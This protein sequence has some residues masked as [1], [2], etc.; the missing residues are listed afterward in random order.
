MKLTKKAYIFGL[1]CKKAAWNLCRDY[2]HQKKENLALA[3]DLFPERKVLLRENIISQDIETILDMRIRPDGQNKGSDICLLKEAASLKEKYLEELAFQKFH[4][5]QNSIQVN[6]TL[7]ILINKAYI[8]KE[9]IDPKKL[10]VI[11]DVTDDVSGIALFMKEKYE[12]ILKEVK[13]ES[14]PERYMGPHCRS[15][16]ILKRCWSDVPKGSVLELFNGG[17]RAF[18]LYQKS[19]QM[20]IDLPEDV[21]L[22]YA[23]TIQKQALQTGRPFINKA[24]IKEFLSSTETPFIYFDI[25]GSSPSIPIFEGTKPFQQIPTLFSAISKNEINFIPKSINDPRESFLQKLKEIPREGTIF[26]FD[27]YFEKARLKELAVAYPKEKEMISRILER[28]VDLHEIFKKIWF[29]HPKQRGKTT[30]KDVYQALFTESYT[31]MDGYDANKDIN[32]FFEGKK[33]D[34]SSVYEYC[35]KDVLAIQKIHEYIQKV[36]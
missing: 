1:E 17:K 20:I 35:K 33:K 8:Y 34:L 2:D 5:E 11:H 6:R 29:Y 4:C 15:C 13:K 36:Y 14:E 31:E 27:A 10:F 9:S 16:P 18:G 7:I 21:R 12:T 30:L 3:K 28:I 19:I 22:P 23:Q 25:E 32:L 24:A 26:C